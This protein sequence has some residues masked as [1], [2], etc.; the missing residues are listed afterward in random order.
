MPAGEPSPVSVNTFLGN[1]RKPYAKVHHRCY[2]DDPV[3]VI[4]YLHLWSSWRQLFHASCTGHLTN[5]QQLALGRP[6]TL[7]STCVYADDSLDSRVEHA[8][9]LHVTCMGYGTDYRQYR[10]YSYMQ[11]AVVHSDTMYCGSLRKQ[12]DSFTFSMWEP[13]KVSWQ[14]IGK[15]RW[16]SI[17]MPKPCMA[18][19]KR[20]HSFT[21]FHYTD[22][23][24]SLQHDQPLPSYRRCRSNTKHDL[25]A[26]ARWHLLVNLL[27]AG[28]RQ[29]QASQASV[30]SACSFA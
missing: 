29:Q 15:G 22:F 6:A 14:R 3:K 27:L 23:G 25:L 1:P 4:G 21:D 13:G 5:Q 12:S 11:R 17:H 24:H 9:D 7:F 10:T 2:P 28:C 30:S 26:H 16:V 18:G 20:A 19:L 8:K